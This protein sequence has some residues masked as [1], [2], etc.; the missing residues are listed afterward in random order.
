[1]PFLCF[2]LIQSLFLFLILKKITIIDPQSSRMLLARFKLMSLK[3]LM[4]VKCLK[5]ELTKQNFFIYTMLQLHML[6]ELSVNSAFF[7]GSSKLK[8][9]NPAY[10]HHIGI[11]LFLRRLYKLFILVVNIDH[12][13]TV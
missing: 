5:T 6:P 10:S 1:M 2:L 7:A 3:L 13:L 12:F 8:M 9:A 11:L 4:R